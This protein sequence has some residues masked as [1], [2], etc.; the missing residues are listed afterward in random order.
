MGN[1]MSV[2]NVFCL[3]KCSASVVRSPAE[4]DAA[5]GIVLPGVGAFGDGME[6]LKIN[7]W[8]EELDVNI[9]KR[10]KP[11]LGICLGMQ[12]LATSG[13][14]GGRHEGL[15]WIDGTVDRMAGDGS[16]RIPH[17]G[18][19]DVNFVKKDGLYHG[20]KDPQAFYFVHSY[21]FLPRDKSCVSG[22]FSYGSE[23]A[24]SIEK[25]NIFAVQFHPE[26]SQSAGIALIKNF[27]NR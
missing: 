9:I 5:D 10:R 19:N 12:L 24:A 15:G 22:I 7:G 6:H 2:Y 27:L 16:I 11:F 18:W 23:Y 25:D 20:L 13:A 4:L 21:T 1:L 3:L 17:I 14:E 26:K 8:V